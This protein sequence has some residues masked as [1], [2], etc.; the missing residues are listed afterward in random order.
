M[1]TLIYDKITSHGYQNKNFS[2]K[3]FTFRKAPLIKYAKLLEITCPNN[4]EEEKKER[5]KKSDSHFKKLNHNQKQTNPKINLLI[6]LNHKAQI[7]KTIKITINVHISY[8]EFVPENIVNL[9]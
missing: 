5:K 7:H 4:S 1:N 2:Q 3:L 9:S 6:I 8:T